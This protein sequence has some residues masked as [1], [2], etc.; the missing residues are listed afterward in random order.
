MRD[1]VAT[2]TFEKVIEKMAGVIANNGALDQYFK[3][4]SKGVESMFFVEIKEFHKTTV[5]VYG[6]NFICSGLFWC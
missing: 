1:T 3:N 2:N 6:K 5:T 4:R